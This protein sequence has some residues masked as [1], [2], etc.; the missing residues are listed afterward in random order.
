MQ[1]F[2]KILSGMANSVFVKGLHYLHMP[3]YQKL[4]GTKCLDIHH[5]A[6]LCK[7]GLSCSKHL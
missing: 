7:A 4:W 1:L 6:L 5:N 3:F 2:L